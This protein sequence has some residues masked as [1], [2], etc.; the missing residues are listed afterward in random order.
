MIA[1]FNTNRELLSAEA[2][3]RR[4][5]GVWRGWYGAMIGLSAL[6]CL[7]MLARGPAPNLIAWLILLGGV[8]ATVYQPRYGVYL[9]AGLSLAGDLLLLPWYPFNKNFSSAESALFLA[10]GVIVSPIETM[11]VLT[12]AVWVG[13]GLVERKLE[14]Y[15]GPLFWPSLL[16]IISIT[17]G[18]LY[19]IGRGGNVNIA[20]WSTRYMFLLPLMLVLVSNLIQT[21]AHVNSLMWWIA[22]G[23]IFN[24]IAGFIYVAS[25][26]KFDTSQVERIAEHTSSVHINTI[27]IL[28]ALA[29]YFRGSFW[30]RLVLPPTLIVLAI[31]YFANQRRASYIALAFAVICF[32]LLLFWQNRR[33]F[34]VL[35]PL[36]AVVGTLYLA[37]FWNGGGGPIGAPAFTIR[38]SIAP[39]P[40]SHEDGSNLYRKLENMNTMFTI[41]QAPIT[42]VGFGNKFIA[43]VP[44]ADI[45]F[46][47]WWEYITHNSILWIWMQSGA[48]AFFALLFLIGFAVAYGARTLLR[49]PRDDMSAIGYVA[50][51]YIL[52]H[53]VFA[54]VDMSWDAQNMMYVGAMM[55]L[56]NAFE[57]I[58]SRPI[59]MPPPRW[60]WQTVVPPPPGLRDS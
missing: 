40:G 1:T 18:L 21:R 60:A 49:L 34:W 14:F 57:R 19:G 7:M 50:L 48:L 20:L 25:E 37:A 41:K 24:S 51:F 59:P 30:K 58:L 36:G 2:Q 43:I 5:N 28:A 9:I 4:A 33:L 17:I 12:L 38:N 53:F 15:A 44:M 35:V 47:I 11:I 29:W 31:S 22:A 45:S 27:F 13:R 55:G 3:K 52:M 26:L 46:F 10:N 56:L 54:Y 23:I 6:I 16:F 32:A 42:G 39:V 8:V